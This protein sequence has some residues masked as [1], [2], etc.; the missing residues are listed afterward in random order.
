MSSGIYNKYTGYHNRRSIRLPGYDYSRP[1]YYFVTFCIHDRRQN[2]FGNVVDAIMVLNEFGKFTKQ[3]WHDIPKHFPNVKIDDF[4]VMPN[5]V[6]GIIRICGNFAGANNYSPLQIQI[7]GQTT[8][9]SAT[10]HEPNGYM[11]IHTKQIIHPCGTSKTV[12]SIVRG[13]KIGVSKM[14]HKHSPGKT[15]WQRGYYDHIIRNEKSLFFIRKYIRE[16]PTN[17][18]VDS[19]NHIDSEIQKFEMVETGGIQ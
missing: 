11:H 16:N 2:L 17:W 3:C 6:H 4:I 7:R 9:K 15:I 19:E 5:H 12:G 10:P 18:C 14:F 13:F 8:P 1:G